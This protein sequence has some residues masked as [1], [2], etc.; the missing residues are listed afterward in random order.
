MVASTVD[1]SP[2]QG[3]GGLLAKALGLEAFVPRRGHKHPLPAALMSALTLGAETF[4]CSAMDEAHILCVLHLVLHHRE[5]KSSNL[6]RADK[7]NPDIAYRM[8]HQTSRKKVDTYQHRKVC[9]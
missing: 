6:S 4:A 1:V 9:M 8:T 7:C 2:K 5:D 3:P